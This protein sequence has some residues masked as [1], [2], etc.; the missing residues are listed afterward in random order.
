MRTAIVLSAICLAATSSA[1]VAQSNPFAPKQGGLTDAEIRAAVAAEMQKQQQ[2]ASTI[3]PAE[4]ANIEAQS[5]AVAAEP[6]PDP[7]SVLLEAGGAFV[8]C[9][10]KTPVFKDKVGRRAYFTSEELGNSHEA[11]RYARC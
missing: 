9:V 2:Q 7:V 3:D 8:G 11:R 10:G 5:G 6:I 1:A 4:V